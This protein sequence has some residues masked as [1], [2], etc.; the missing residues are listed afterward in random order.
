MDENVNVMIV[1]PGK[2]A[3]LMKLPLA[4]ELMEPGALPYY[5]LVIAISF[6]FSGYTGLYASQR[7]MYSKTKSSYINKT[8]GG[9]D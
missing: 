1:E 9:E 4:L 6:C 2:P 8:V 3:K 7:I 5:S